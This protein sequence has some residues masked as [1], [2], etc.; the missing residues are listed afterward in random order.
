MLPPVFVLLRDAAIPLTSRPLVFLR[1]EA[2]STS[3]HS[4]HH[5]C[6][7]LVTTVQVATLL[8]CTPIT[9][10]ST[11][12]YPHHHGPWEQ[13]QNSANLS[14]DPDFSGLDGQPKV[15]AALSPGDFESQSSINRSDRV[16]RLSYP[17][18]HPYGGRLHGGDPHQGSLHHTPHS[19]TEEEHHCQWL[20]SDN[21]PCEFVGSQDSLKVHINSEHLFGAQD[22]PNVC[23]WKGCRYSRRGKPE[24]HTMRR[25]S[26]WR[27]I[28]EK[29]L[30]VKFRKKVKA[31]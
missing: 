14:A 22:A 28:L 4:I 13:S 23:L 7:F 11:Y 9:R 6:M 1:W 8:T 26:A 29:H 25:D 31:P 15:L 2:T 10:E 20:R 27:H 12:N 16:S 5:K 3:H 24:V 19:P 21:V 30:D 17:P 18:V